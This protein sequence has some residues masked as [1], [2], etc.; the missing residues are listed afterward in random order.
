MTHVDFSCQVTICRAVK[1]RRWRS[2]AAA[3]AAPVRLSDVGS[4]VAGLSGF[5]VWR[6]LGYQISAAAL[7]G[8]VRLSDVGSSA[9]LSGC[10]TFGSSTA[11]IR[12]SDLAPLDVTLQGC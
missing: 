6:S 2:L 9:A 5:V 4:S 1:F 8:V 11:D 3:S 12:L 7:S 10:Q